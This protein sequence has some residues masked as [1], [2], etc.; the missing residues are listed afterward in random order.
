MKILSGIFLV[1]VDG[2][3]AV[4]NLKSQLQEKA[5]VMADRP[6]LFWLP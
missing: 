3:S 5:A 2:C 4:N 6:I 1:S